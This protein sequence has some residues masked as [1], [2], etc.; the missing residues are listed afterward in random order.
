MVDVIRSTAQWQW[1]QNMKIPKYKLL[2]CSPYSFAST[3]AIE[4]FRKQSINDRHYRYM[5]VELPSVNVEHLFQVRYVP[6][7]PKQSTSWTNFEPQ[8]YD[9]S[10]NFYRIA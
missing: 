8:V 6:M 7:F 4:R 1:F 5:I 2:Y 9:Q 3:L 10:D